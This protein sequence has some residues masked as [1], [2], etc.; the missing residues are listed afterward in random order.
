M[1]VVWALGSRSW[2]DRDPLG[3]LG[4]TELDPFRPM[5]VSADLESILMN[6]RT[7]AESVW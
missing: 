7:T 2:T 3:A 6:V 1:V 5:V 4:G